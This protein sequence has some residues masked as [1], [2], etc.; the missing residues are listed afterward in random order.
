M[1]GLT[2]YHPGDLH[3]AFDSQRQLRDRIDYMFFPAVKLEGVEITVIDNV[4]PRFL[5]PIHHRVDAPDFP[6]PAPASIRE[7]ELVATDLAHGMPKPGADP[8]D[9]RREIHAM[10]NAHWYPTP[11]P[12]LRRVH[13]LE[14]QIQQLGTEMLVLD[15]GQPHSLSP[16][17]P[18]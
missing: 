5:V 8:R 11:R 12:P 6:I 14:Q 4:R 18:K 7:D 9:Y 3:E 1:T 2:F 15:A 16:L 17:R 10:F 13:A